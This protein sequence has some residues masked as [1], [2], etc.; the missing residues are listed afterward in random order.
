MYIGGGTVSLTSCTFSANTAVSGTGERA[1]VRRGHA[2]AVALV[3]GGERVKEG[4]ERRESE[5]ARA[6]EGAEREKQARAMGAADWLHASCLSGS[7]GVDGA[8][9][10]RMN[11][12]TP[13]TNDGDDAGADSL[14][15]CLPA[16]I[17][18]DDDGNDGN[19]GGIR[20]SSM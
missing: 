19:D 10:L 11:D 12:G 20:L 9:R 8:I 15:A 18:N 3:R 16:C 4:H 17:A 2:K 13:T 7:C 5:S 14:P 6:D 1:S